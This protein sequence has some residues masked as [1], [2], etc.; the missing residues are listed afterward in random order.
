MTVEAQIQDLID[1]C[2]KRMSEDEKMRK[3]VEALMKV[4]NFDLS[5]ERYSMRLENAKIVDF[6]PEF[7]D[8]ADVVV[9]TTPEYF[10]QLM[11]GDLRPMRAYITKKVTIKGKVQDLMFLKKFF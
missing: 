5:T 9:T 4:F 7:A 6:K 2:N 11:N 8:N 1:K 10:E 3:E